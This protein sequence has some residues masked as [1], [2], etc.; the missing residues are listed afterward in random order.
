MGGV[1]A[2]SGDEYHNYLALTLTLPDQLVYPNVAYEFGVSAVNPPE[3]VHPN[4]WGLTLLNS[5]KEVVDASMTLDGYHLTDFGLRV[6]S[7][8]A[9]SVLPTVVN[10]VRVTLTFQ[11]QLAPGVVGHLTIRAPSTSKVLCQRFLDI[12][13]GG[14]T[15]MMLPLDPEFGVYGT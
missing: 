7:L 14:S 13:G 5:R 11:R 1:I 15:S 3:P 9:S 8:L 10:Y 2:S 4:F 12:S 6:D